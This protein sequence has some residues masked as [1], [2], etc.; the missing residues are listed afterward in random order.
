MDVR[1]EESL[2]HF[3][4]QLILAMKVAHESSQNSGVD[5]LLQETGKNETRLLGWTFGRH[6]LG[7]DELDALN[8]GTE[9]RHIAARS[10]IDTVGYVLAVQICEAMNNW[11][12]NRPWNKP[13]M[14]PNNDV[15]S[16]YG[17]IQF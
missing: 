1:F 2:K 8:V 6:T 13:W 9:R 15:V 11:S 16:A 10:L 7:H 14:H 3:E 5:Q 17:W 4:D 12:K